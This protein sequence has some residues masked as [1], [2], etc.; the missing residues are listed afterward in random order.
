MRDTEV[1]DQYDIA[2]QMIWYDK[3]TKGAFFDACRECCSINIHHLARGWRRPSRGEV[4]EE[5]SHI[6]CLCYSKEVNEAELN[7][8]NWKS[9]SIGATSQLFCEACFSVQMFL[10]E[11]ALVTSRTLISVAYLG[12][13][14]HSRKHNA[15][16]SSSLDIILGVFLFCF[17]QV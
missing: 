3:R 16:W 5:R 6:C 4:R 13:L 11:D 14:L 12:S 8:D 1:D 17:I 15:F 9:G 10:R 7:L 2:V